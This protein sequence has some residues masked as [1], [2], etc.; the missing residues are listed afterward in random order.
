M[1][2]LYS[3]VII[4]ALVGAGATIVSSVA[5]PERP[6]DVGVVELEPEVIERPLRND[7]PASALD[8]A[9]SAARRIVTRVPLGP[10]TVLAVPVG[11]GGV[12]VLGDWD[13]DGFDEPGVWFPNVR[14]G[15]LRLADGTILASAGSVDGV[16]LAGDWDGDGID[17]I[18]TWD[19]PIDPS[20]S[21]VAGDWDGDGIDEIVVVPL[22]GGEATGVIA[23]DWDGDGVDTLAT[24][25]RVSETRVRIDGAVPAHP[26]VGETTEIDVA[27]TSVLVSGLFDA[28]LMADGFRRLRRSLPDR[29]PNRAVDVEPSQ[30]GPDGAEI[31]LAR[32]W[33]IVIDKTMADDLEAL[34][35]AAFLDGIELGGWGMRSN[36]QQIELRKAHCGTSHYAIY[37]A[38]PSSCSPPTARPGHSR[39]EHGRAVD[40]TQGGSVLTRSSTG[41]HWL[42]QHASK[43]GFFNL[44]SEPWHWS[45]TGG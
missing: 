10:D 1:S 39:H 19:A 34:L 44:P 33:G 13:G 25:E 36:A 37:E 41:F 3:V 23:G 4:A 21:I 18:A 15:A 5:A 43:Y 45:D 35:T 38:S 7:G 12:P 8:P 16:P 31:Q 17:T 28:D 11:P 6:L 30:L 20:T 40:F 2:R 27:P 26:S 22:A 24:V 42:Q 32:V 9:E 29:L 14:S